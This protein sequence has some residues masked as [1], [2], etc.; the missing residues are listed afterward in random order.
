MFIGLRF[1]GYSHLIDFDAFGHVPF[2]PAAI[3]IVIS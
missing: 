2:L 1:K 3:V